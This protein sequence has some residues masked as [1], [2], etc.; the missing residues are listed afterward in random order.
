MTRRERE[1]AHAATTD[2]PSSLDT[3]DVG[4]YK[5][6]KSRSKEPGLS[7]LRAGRRLEEGIVITVEP[8]IYFIK[9]L[10]DRAYADENLAR[11]LNKE[12][13]ERCRSFGGVRIEDNVVVTR[14]GIENLTRCPR[15]VDEIEAVMAGGAWE[16]PFF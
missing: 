9:P 6:G 13:I 1:R 10:L 5:V 11:F 8:G 4:G 7:S 2:D 3:H 15:T 16:V 12:K 14:D